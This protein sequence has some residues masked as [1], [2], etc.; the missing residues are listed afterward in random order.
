M[1]KPDVA[2]Q[3]LEEWKLKSEDEHRAGSDPQPA[4]AA[5]LPKPLRTIA[6][7]LLDRDEV[8]KGFDLLDW[9]THSPVKTRP[10]SSLTRCH[11]ANACE[12]SRRSFPGLQNRW[13]WPGS[14]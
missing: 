10:A 7:E 2:K 5:R 6:Y 4:Q 9:E 1:L 3:Q 11:R 8:G 13:S 14:S 12:Y